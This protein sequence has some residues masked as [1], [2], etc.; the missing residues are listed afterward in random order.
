MPFIELRDQETRNI[1]PGCVTRFIHTENMTVSYWNLD[2]GAVIPDHSHPHEQVTNIVE[3]E[4]DLT[5]DGETKRLVPGAVAYIPSN[6]RH[7]GTAV[8]ECYVLDVFHPVR[9]DY[10]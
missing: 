4:M 6:V 2:A 8:T 1:L 3:G 5:V 7:S 10:R 9:E